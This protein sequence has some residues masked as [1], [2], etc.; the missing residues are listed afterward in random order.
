MQFYNHR[1]QHVKTF[2]QAAYKRLYSVNMA[3]T[4]KPKPP[5]LPAVLNNSE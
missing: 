2:N 5:R 3:R 4:S 1:P